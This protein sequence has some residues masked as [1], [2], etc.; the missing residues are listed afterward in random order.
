MRLWPLL[1][2]L[3]PLTAAAQLA[4]AKA[5]PHM[6]AVPLPH[7]ITSFQLDG[8]ELTAM[9]YDPQDM[10]P[11]WYP[12]RSSHEASLT[13]MGHPH[14]P[15][16]HSHHNSVWITHNSVNEIDFWG[17]HAKKQGRIINV[18]VSREGYEDSDEHAAMRMVNHWI[19]EADQSPQLIEVRRTEIRP[20]D[21]ARSWFMIID[22]EYTAPKGKTTTFGPTGFGLVAV[23]MAKSIGV[24][25]GGGRILN[26]AGQENEAAV[27]R[28]PA[29]WCDYSGRITPAADGF[30]G[31]T[32]MN[33]PMNP[34]NPTAFHVRDDGW[35]GCCLSL[36]TPV[37]VTNSA[38]LRLRYGLWVHDGVP[39]QSQSQAHW[40]KFCDLPI[41]ELNPKKK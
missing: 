14:D 30:A 15:L 39:T 37:V 9:H 7:Y 2:L 24:H 36:D 23:R 4:T 17:D 8:R 22:L 20:L 1:I 40:Q 11:F 35:M 29:L 18:E 27:F 6:Q 21:G 31:I 25:D 26:S 16:T 5:I 19:S 10:R 34:H 28:K 33:H 3:S 32:L 41:T 38:P 12:I 13:R